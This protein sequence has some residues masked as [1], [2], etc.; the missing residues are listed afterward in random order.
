MRKT[1]QH[2]TTKRD[3]T[4]EQLSF[5]LQIILVAQTYTLNEMYSFRGVGEIVEPF[6]YAQG[7]VRVWVTLL[8][9]PLSS[10]LLHQKSCVLY[11][12]L[13][14]PHSAWSYL[15]GYCLPLKVHSP[16]TKSSTQLTLLFFSTTFAY[17]KSDVIQFCNLT[18]RTEENKQLSPP[19]PLFSF[20]LQIY[21][22]MFGWCRW[23][24]WI[25]LSLVL[26]KNMECVPFFQWQKQKSWNCLLSKCF[27]FATPQLIPTTFL[28]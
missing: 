28:R 10:F 23:N 8:M 6:I 27:L 5:L 11:L 2:Q 3:Y 24:L 7:S 19:Y 16:N 15:L 22:P 17:M 18:E 1:W 12:N 21:L 9:H 4:T 20:L 26:L 14:A 13:E 25:E